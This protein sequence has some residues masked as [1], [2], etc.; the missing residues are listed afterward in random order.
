MSMV[1]IFKRKKRISLILLWRAFAVLLLSAGRRFR[2]AG[3]IF[4]CFLLAGLLFSQSAAYAVEATVKVAPLSDEHY[5][6][7]D[8]QQAELGR[9]LF[10]D[11][12][13]SGN[14]NISCGTCHHPAFGTSDG[15][16]LGVGE[17]GAG[18]G[19]TRTAGYGSSRIERRVPRNAPAL[20]NLGA[21]EINVLMHDGRIS[22]SDL[23]GN[24]FNTPAQEWLP[25]GLHS[26][27][28][29]QALFPLTSET[30]M[31]G[32]NEENEVAGAANDRIDNAW[33]IIAKR[34]RTIPQYAARFVA[35]F[36]SVDQAGDITIVPIANALA[37]F[38][39]LEFRS[40]DSAYDEWLAGN[41]SALD[42]QQHNGRL[43]F[44]GKATCHSCHGGALFSSHEFKALAVPAF[45]PGRTR[46]FDP[47]ARDVGRMGESDRLQDAYRFRV[48]MLRNVEL[49]GPYGHNGAFTTL[50]SMIRHHIDPLGSN[51][52]WRSSTPLLA[53][54]D[55]LAPTDFIIRQDK[56]EMQRQLRKIDIALPSLS[57]NE[58]D[59]LIAFLKS[60]T[61]RAAKAQASVVPEV[62]P[63]GLPVVRLER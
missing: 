1:E 52:Q 56:F 46:Q 31:A 44:F 7:V 15:F 25:Q 35:A 5:H 43:L 50:E 34:V 6:P 19:P 32:A 57:D 16:S 3:V 40:A 17:G 20:W 23:Y 29:A 39:S 28:A 42:K 24:G 60:L 11:N 54:A 37:A 62:V 2:Q 41:E 21:K 9:L 8:T 38:I 45:G 27:V 10:Y 49:T 33:P 12:V 22:S 48:P 47:I 63:S 14:R 58:I 36:D 55:W 53:S 51:D 18:V 4:T 13:L 59:D 61:G 26:V 30:E